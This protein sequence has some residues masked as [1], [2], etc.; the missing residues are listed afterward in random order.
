MMPPSVEQYTIRQKVFKIFGDS[1][2]IFDG[3]GAQVGYC[4]QKFL[5]LRE[6]LRFY[7]DETRSTELFSMRA[8]SILDFS[9]TYDVE[10]PDG[11]SLGSLRRRGFTSFVRDEWIVFDPG[12]REIARIREDSMGLAVLRRI[13]PLASYFVP[14][15][16]ELHRTHGEKI[17][18]GSVPLAV[19]R[20]HFSL[21]VYKLGIAIAPGLAETDEAF[22]DLLVLAAGCLLAAI[23]GRQGD[24]SSGTGL[25]SGE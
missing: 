18:E 12:E 1:F 13:L 15:K 9:T 14:Q 17:A 23:E 24:D 21:F 4:K 8:R 5:R 6:D 3:R 20:T 11:A 16:F 25:F 10:L 2:Q 22:D 7:T 19:Y